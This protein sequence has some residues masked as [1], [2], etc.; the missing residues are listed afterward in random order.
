MW[1]LSILFIYLPFLAICITSIT[2]PVIAK[3]KVAGNL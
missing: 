3:A 1:N 2:I